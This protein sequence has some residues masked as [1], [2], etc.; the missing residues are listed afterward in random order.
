M[1][2]D[3]G[4]DVCFA[5]PAN[6]V[7]CRSPIGT[8]SHRSGGRPIPRGL[9]QAFRADAGAFAGM[10]R[11]SARRPPHQVWIS[12]RCGGRARRY[13]AGRDRW[14]LV[15]AEARHR[16]KLDSS[17]DRAEAR[18]AHARGGG[19][20]RSAWQAPYRC[21]VV[22]VGSSPRVPRANLVSPVSTRPIRTTSNF[23]FSCPGLSLQAGA[24]RSGINRAQQRPPG[25]AAA[26]ARPR[27]A[28]RRSTRC[29]RSSR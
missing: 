29:R 4:Q 11:P 20:T 13:A 14:R 1:S 28:S 3:S 12:R 21:A 22:A 16:Q 25:C 17:F 2:S 26:P 7:E 15:R 24:T 19:Y 27:P 5:M 6:P 10:D 9:R 8:S 23:D 18:R